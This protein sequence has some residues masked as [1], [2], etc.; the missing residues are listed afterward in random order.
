ML[1]IIKVCK[2]G[3]YMDKTKWMERNKE[4][5][6]KL[7]IMD[8]T[9]F[10]K[11]VED[12]G[13]CEEMIRTIL[14]ND[15]IVVTENTPQKFLRNVGTRSVILDVLCMDGDGRMVNIEVQKANNDDHQRR[16]RYN[17]SNIDTFVTEKSTLFEEMPDVCI[18]YISSFDIF[19][20]N[21]TIY[22]IDRTIRETGTVVDNGFY[23][24]YVNTAVDDGSK[25][26]EL[27]QY[28]K[29]TK[30]VCSDFPRISRRVKYFKEEQ[31]GVKDMCE[32]LEKY[33]IEREQEGLAEGERREAKRV[34]KSMFE[35]GMSYDIV[36]KCI[37]NLSVEELDK[38]YEEVKR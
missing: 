32:L 13:V 3:G 11:I 10:H 4:I 37:Q 19:E 33:G 22:H 20:E 16:V 9:F 24:V 23:E 21:R 15:K 28:M 8:D 27:M 5:L 30:G 35:Q 34:A 31:E 14:E 18:I 38:I 26:A 36:K 12:A 17:A 6:S 1:D 29:D 2:R 25:K 7:N